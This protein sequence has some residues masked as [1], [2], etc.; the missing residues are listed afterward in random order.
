[1]PADGHW[2]LQVEDQRRSFCCPGCLGV[3]Q[4]ILA[5]GLGN[6]Y[7]QREQP[8]STAKYSDA[9]ELAQLELYD[10]SEIQSSFVKFTGATREAA[11]ILENI[12]CPACLWL[13]EQHLRGLSG[14][15]AVEIDYTSERAWVQWDAGQTKLS[16]ILQAIRDIGYI[17]H[18]YDAA[19]RQRLLGDRKRRNTER[20]LFAGLIGMTVMELSL[21]T[22]LVG[23]PDAHGVLPLWVIVGRWTALLAVTAIL[24]YPAQEF[25]VG[26]WRDLRN[27]RVGM[28]VPIVFGLL[29]AY[30]GSAWATVQQHGE[31]YY[32]SIGMFV[33]FVLLARRFELRGRLS[34]ATFIDRLTRIVPRT[35][36]R[37]NRDGL[38]E[39]VP[40]VELLAHDLVRIVPGETV[41]IDGRLVQGHSSF[42]EALLTG[43]SSPVRHDIGDTL[44]AGATNINQTVLVEVT[45]RSA[46]SMVCVL[47]RLLEHGM[48]TRPPS[49]ALAELTA[50]WFVRAILLV[51]TATAGLWLWLEPDA[52]VANTVAVL[53][54]T[55]PCALALATPV[56]VSLATARF[57]EHG[58]LP[59]KPAAIE[60]LAKTD[61][62]AFDKTGT[63]TLG[64]PHVAEIHCPSSLNRATALQLAAALERDSSHPV[65]NALKLSA[66]TD[67][68]W[69]ID[70][71]S[72]HAGAGVSAR[73][74]G[75][76][77]KLGNPAFATA[78]LI[79]P[80]DTGE[81]IRRLESAG[82]IV[83]VLADATSVQAVFALRDQPRPALASLVEQLRSQGV[84]QFA[85]LSGDHQR[86]VND[87]AT[88]LGIGTALGDLRAEQKLA[89]IGEQQ[90]RGHRIAMVGDGLNDAATLAAADASVS[91]AEAPDLTQVSSDFLLLTNDLHGI[92][93]AH[94]LARKTRR[95][96]IQG[97]TWAALYNVLAIPAAALGYV[98]PWAAAIGMSASSLLVVANALRL[99]RDSA[100]G[101][102]L[103]A[104]T[105]S[106]PE[107]PPTASDLVSNAG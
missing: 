1:M 97:L 8:A 92:V 4:T 21:A 57:V 52:A 78:D 79:M 87:L 44:I 12:R 33:F 94:R 29:T 89:W 91:F 68:P 32:D 61:L 60:T 31:V 5:G 106:D 73:V 105:T 46:D 77:W 82:N 103:C 26:A 19:H 20:L 38:S 16:T 14:V 96:I 11:L 67:C 37:I 17:A 90:S 84:T 88:T 23:Q 15:L 25:F 7:R 93:R 95:I 24:A 30:V 55:C 41:P 83:V 81:L 40:V 56:A 80:V 65:A 22:Y 69:V 98:P 2:H 35:A 71:W 63:L 45:R 54:V 99:R 100:L 62:F 72:A 102:S 18:P 66:G 27:R 104:R 39:R 75:A 76:W 58:I 6:Y 10:R 64:R 28:D 53:I 34:A 36:T 48:R 70:G 51:A 9:D 74:D 3:C 85:I 107:S 50:A 49:V 59:V 43:E 101:R 42:D 86:N 13:N 47:Q